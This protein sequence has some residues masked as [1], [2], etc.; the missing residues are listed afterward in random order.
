MKKHR[1]ILEIGTEGGVFEVCESFNGQ[2]GFFYRVEE[3]KYPNIDVLKK[4]QQKTVT[5]TLEETLDALQKK[6]SAIWDF[7]PVFCHPEYS[8]VII[9]Y[10]KQH[11]KHKASPQFSLEKWAEVLGLN[12][13]TLLKKIAPNNLGLTKKEKDVLI[14]MIRSATHKVSKLIEQGKI[15]TGQQFEHIL[16]EKTI[17][18]DIFLMVEKFTISSGRGILGDPDVE[19]FMSWGKYKFVSTFSLLEP[20]YKHE[21]KTPF[22]Q[23][24]VV[25]EVTEGYGL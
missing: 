18:H 10:L 1:V 5:N 15:V 24:F 9:T 4:E 22:A 11:I 14:G 6:Y 19:I 20:S 25:E 23:R 7:H 16:E 8:A 17:K 2:G 3:M 12:R 21:N 13:E